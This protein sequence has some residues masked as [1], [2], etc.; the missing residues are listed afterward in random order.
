MG[1]GG[2]EC[3][4]EGEDRRDGR[5]DGRQSLE[6]GETEEVGMNNQACEGGGESFTRRGRR[7]GMVEKEDRPLSYQRGIEI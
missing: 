3:F 6:D 7:A 5:K 2:S 4:V 1:D